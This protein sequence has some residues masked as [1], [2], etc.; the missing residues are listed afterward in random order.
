M[1]TKRPRAR[2]PG[3]REY[4]NCILIP[5][6]CRRARRFRSDTTMADSDALTS[7]LSAWI[8]SGAKLLDLRP[9]EAYLACRLLSS[10]TRNVPAQ[11]VDGNCFELPPREVA[12]GLLAATAAE[13]STW[14][15][16]LRSREWTV[17]PECVF[18]GDEA[19]WR[20]AS[21]LGLLEDAQS[22]L[23]ACFLCEP[24]PFL[25]ECIPTIER[26]LA[27]ARQPAVSPIWTACDVGCG[28]GRDTVWLACRALTP[29]QPLW[30]VVGMDF[31]A[32]HLE[33]I[34]AFA[35]SFGDDVA[36]RVRT[37]RGKILDDGAVRICDVPV[38]ADFS[39]DR[40][41]LVLG[42]RFLERNFFPSTSENWALVHFQ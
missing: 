42:V 14:C 17:L 37:T 16:W 39:T 10:R 35:A 36:A 33:R 34:R 5:D 27:L 21:S 3:G 29:P 4:C 28:C 19:L 6:R 38:T 11:L 12:F 24:C 23:R 40:Y 2:G 25:S 41:D 26:E 18:V 1:N 30:S 20:A 31:V 13:A 22:P 7:A 8:T 9:R 15:T 32:P